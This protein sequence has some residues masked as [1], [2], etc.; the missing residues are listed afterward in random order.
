MIVIDLV[1]ERPGCGRPRCHRFD[2]VLLVVPGRWIVAV[3]ESYQV[4]IAYSKY[5]GR[6]LLDCMFL[7]GRPSQYSWGV[8]GDHTTF[9]FLRWQ[10]AVLIIR[11]LCCENCLLMWLWRCFPLF[12][13][14]MLVVW[15]DL[16]AFFVDFAIFVDKI[17]QLLVPFFM[18]KLFTLV[19]VD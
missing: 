4:F 16:C 2:W 8:R 11:R 3:F 13:E 18:F 12:V 5:R 1:I 9:Y 19:S 14:L 15:F 10:W 6:F 7:V 17:E